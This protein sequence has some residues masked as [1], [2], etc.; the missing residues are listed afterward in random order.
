MTNL[1][2]VERTARRLM[3]ENGLH[4]IPFK[5]DGGKRRLGYCQYRWWTVDGRREYKVTGISISRHYASILPIEEMTQ[6]IL[7]EIAH[8][9]TPGHKHDYVWQRQARLLGHTGD[10]CAT[11]SAV[12]E[13]AWKGVC[14]NGHQSEQ[15]R[16]PRRMKSCGKCSRSFKAAN[17]LVWSKNGRKVSINE[18]PEGFRNDYNMTPGT[19]YHAS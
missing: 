5:F 15:I 9:L 10:R 2:E 12:P 13:G 18:M 4:H 3:D 7:H 11:P 16:A 1:N 8:A 19:P 17:V 14:P 6:T